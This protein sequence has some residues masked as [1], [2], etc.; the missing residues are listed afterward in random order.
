MSKQSDGMLPKHT[1]ATLAHTAK[2]REKDRARNEN[3]SCERARQMPAS[4]TQFVIYEVC[5]A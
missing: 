1:R 2:R 5:K 3:E 4:K